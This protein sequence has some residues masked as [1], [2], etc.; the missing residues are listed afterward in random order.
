[1]SE[2]KKSEIIESNFDMCSF[3]CS[4][5]SCNNSV[6]SLF[7][8]NMTNNDKWYGDNSETNEAL[9]ALRPQRGERN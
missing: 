1:M 8:W 2:E 5:F 3:V 7:L 6:S 9:R 4:Y